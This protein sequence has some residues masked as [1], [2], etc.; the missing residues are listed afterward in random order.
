MTPDSPRLLRLFDAIV[1]RHPRISV[2][3]LAAIFAVFA[4]HARDFRLD[5]SSETLMLEHDADL[6]YSRQV[7][8]R[9]GDTDFLLVAYAPKGDLLDDAVLGRIAALRDE[10]KRI[11]SVTSVL[12]ILDL[13]LLESPP[14]PIKEL[15]AGLRTLADPRTDRRLARQEFKQS[16]LYHNLLVSPDLKTTALVVNF[17]SDE[18]WRDLR[19]RRDALRDKAAAEGLTAVETAAYDQVAAEFQAHREQ[20]RRQWHTTI[21]QIRKILDG[22]R[23]E[24]DVFLGGVD[25]I[26]D[27]MLSFIRNDLKVFGTGVLVFLI[28]IL[29]VLFR[30]WRW[31]VLPVVCC[32][33]SALAMVGILGWCDWE[34]TVISSNFISLQLIV[35]MA[36]TIHLIVRYRE[37][38]RQAPRA[39]H[40]RLVRDTVRLMLKPCVYTTLTT[41]AGFA[42]LIFSDIKPVIT[43]GWM[44]IVG[45]VVSMVTTFLLFPSVL[46]LM[47]R[48]KFP[49]KAGERFSLPLHLAHLTRRHG[50]LILLVSALALGFSAWGAARLNV[51]NAFIDY[52][53]HSTEIYQGM[54]IV[55]QTLGGTT[56]LDVVVELERSPVE[57][58]SKDSQASGG[59]EFEAFAEF[60]AVPDD[61]KYWFTKDKIT[62][63]EAVHDYL[64]GLPE[65]GKVLSLATLI[66]I[67]ERLNDNRPLDNFTLALLFGELPQRIREI[68][69]DPYVS[70]AHD[71]ARLSVR[72]ID[73]LP[74]LRRNEL[75][76]RIRSDLPRKLGLPADRIH[77][78]GMMVLYN[79]MLQSLFQSQILTLGATV[80]LLM[81]MFVALFRSL[82]IS[83]IAIFPNLLS[84]AVV[85]G[86]MGWAGIPLDMMTITIAAI[87][88][89]I[90]VDDTIHYIHRFRSEFPRHGTY[91]ATMHHCHGSIGHAMFYTSVVFVIGFSILVLSNFIPT[92]YF[93]LLTG[94][95]MVIALL[96]ALTLL[97]ALI[98][99]IRPFGPESATDVRHAPGGPAPADGN[100]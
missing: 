98:V 13:P 99:A 55:D 89:G 62:T 48:E 30:N 60:D 52:F 24:A 49:P 100:R 57:T 82:R 47:P 6:A 61:P 39:E 67:A 33:A 64:D 75:L 66:K 77:L 14:V 76:D 79:N 4:Y 29:L 51:E 44:M 12:T 1:L 85:L 18:R 58:A 80:L 87:S 94:L 70:I 53:K 50:R 73:S 15:A 86:F 3:V 59:D 9:Y 46:M 7:K 71:E 68:L 97:P 72:I 56:P 91:L 10:L 22:Y 90:A 5:A 78:T 8:A 16:P 17:A 95:A 81:G 41:I 69:V 43:F 31:V 26:A 37:L 34:V 40:R 63:I 96:A 54:K 20:M 19:T 93:G 27:D 23:A 84:I 74:G 42:S 92:I 32:A 45:L 25:M 88:V 2:L 28:L 38:F 65:T 21:V 83:L 11:P 36:I 35:T